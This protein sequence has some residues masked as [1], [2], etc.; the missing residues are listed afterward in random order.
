MVEKVAAPNAFM[1]VS[2]SSR[3]LKAHQETD[4]SKKPAATLEPKKKR[5]RRSF[6]DVA[7]VANVDDVFVVVATSSST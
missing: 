6:V 3:M 2:F 4:L 7:V 5:L 1:F